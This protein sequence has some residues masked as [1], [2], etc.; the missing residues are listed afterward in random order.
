VPGDWQD[1]QKYV[2]ADLFAQTLEVIKSRPLYG[3]PR[4]KLYEKTIT[5]NSKNTIFAVDGKGL[6]FCLNVYAKPGTNQSTDKL[7][8]YIDGKLSQENIIADFKTYHMYAPVQGSFFATLLTPNLDEYSIWLVWI[9]SFDS[10]VDVY[11]TE[12]KGNAF[13]V[14]AWICH[15]FV[16]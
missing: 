9:Q 11:Y 7:Q 6:H 12:T 2:L 13:K 1:Y 5:A 8:V 15:S 4:R 3:I 10:S 14:Y 16:T